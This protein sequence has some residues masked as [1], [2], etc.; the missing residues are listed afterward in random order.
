MKK[1]ILENKEEI[2][3]GDVIITNLIDPEIKKS[4]PKTDIRVKESARAS[5]K[6]GARDAKS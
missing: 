4:T 6:Y 2:L 1:R 5:T 3:I